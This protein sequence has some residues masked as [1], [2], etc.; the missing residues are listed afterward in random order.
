MPPF[1]ASLT[2][3][4]LAALA[5]VAFATEGRSGVALLCGPSGVGKSTVLDHLAADIR[6]AG[7]SCTVADISA[8]LAADGDLPDV[9]LADNAHAASDADLMRLL[10]RCHARQ[11]MAAVVLAGQGRLLTLVARDRRLEQAIRLRA[12]LLPG[13]LNDTASLLSTTDG[14]SFDDAAIAMIHDVAAGIPADV[15]RLQDLAAVCASSNDEG[16]V[17][18][19]DID[20]IHHRLS[21]IAA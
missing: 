19:E 7:R 1:L 5:K 2:E 18:A 11:P 14:P 12:T 17:T 4:Q 9:V 20:A 8:W 13:R 6:L 3:P 15:M 16:R 21:P 10:A